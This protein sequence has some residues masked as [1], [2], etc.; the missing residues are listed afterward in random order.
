MFVPGVR[1][2]RD[3]IPAV[4]DPLLQA[5]DGISN[6]FI[7]TVK[8]HAASGGAGAASDSDVELYS[9]VGEL[10]DIN[11]ALLRLLGVSHSSLEVLCDVSKR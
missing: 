2:L 11:M 10:V 4:V 9:R 3:K 8:S 7:D 6:V 1:V 5:I